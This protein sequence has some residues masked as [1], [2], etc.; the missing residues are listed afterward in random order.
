MRVPN[1][2]YR[3]QLHREFGFAQARTLVPYLR[4]LGISDL[5]LSSVLEARPGS[6]HGYDVINP[7]K[8]NPELGGDGEFAELAAELQRSGLGLL[9]DIVPNHMAA[10]PLNPWWADVLK[11]GP[12]SPY[13]EFFDIDWQR[14]GGE[15]KVHLPILA[16]PYGAALENQELVLERDA[17]GL[18]IRYGALRLPVAPDSYAAGRTFIDENLREFNG[19]KGKPASF[20][21]LDQ[22]LRAQHYRLAYWRTAPERVNYRRFFD[23]ND[24][25]GLRVEKRCVF[26]AVHALVFRWIAEGIVT[27]LRIDHI[28]GLCK[29][30]QYLERVRQALKDKVVDGEIYVIVEKIL[31]GDEELPHDW[32]VCGT[33]GYDFLNS[34]NGVFVDPRGLERLQVV[35]ARFCGSGSSMADVCYAAKR[36]VLEEL[37]VAEFEARA[38]E[39]SRLAEGDRYARDIPRSHLRRALLEVAACLPVYRT[40]IDGKPVRDADRAAIRRALADARRRARP[41]EMDP[42]TADF[43][44]RTLLLAGEP[45][46][47][48]EALGFVMRWQQ[49]TGPAMA[50]GLEDTAFYRYPAL[51]ALN[52]VGGDPAGGTFTGTQQFHQRNARR[53]QH[54]R[55]ALNATSTHDTKRSEDVRARIDVLSEIPTAWARSVARWSRWNQSKKRRV[56]GAWAPDRCDEMFLYQTLIGAWPLHADELQSFRERI[57]AVMRKSVREAKVH[58]SWINPDSEYERA[59][60]SFVERILAQAPKNRFLPDFRRFHERVAYPGA[61]NALSQVLLKITAPGVPDFYQGTE[62]WDFRLVDPDNRR[63]VDHARRMQMLDDLERAERADRAALLRGLLK[64]WRDGRIKLFVTR[65]ALRFRAEHP[66]LFA[67]ARYVPLRASG[68]RKDHICA[69]ARHLQNEWVLVAVPRLT[70]RRARSRWQGTTLPLR[71]EAPG[72]WRNVL[73]GEILRCRRGALP[74]D[75]L[76]GTFPMA[77]LHGRPEAGP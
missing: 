55:H 21:L 27:G 49:L 37:F 64:N 7:Q 30:A 44:Q 15:G 25:V 67:E 32:P 8:I 28:D 2:T 76:F 3:L 74:A 24:L 77:L 12:G 53:Q 20:Q 68:A 6:T 23:I 43:L 19:V 14:A 9:L 61:L 13:A 10:S 48:A 42:A 56:D 69:F 18:G 58:T 57:V 73:T 4:R 34:V 17:E 41:S 70:A 66:Q 51:I 54:D 63:P 35:A 46:P 31:T 40:Y 26:D 52:E 22:L 5:Y 29:P 75:A 65:A 38:S 71:R 1:A 50:K 36:Q 59:V 62:V 33:T 16:R 45:G 11:N 47:D 72:E 60:T 39:L